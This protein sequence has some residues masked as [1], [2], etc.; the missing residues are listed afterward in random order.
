VRLVRLFE[1]KLLIPL[2]VMDVQ[3]DISSL[4]ILLG[5]GKQFSPVNFSIL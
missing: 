3:L 4:T 5:N 2:R 1:N